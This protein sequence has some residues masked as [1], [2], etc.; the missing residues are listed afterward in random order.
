MSQLTNKRFFLGALSFCLLTVFALFPGD[1][2][3]EEPVEVQ[4]AA[5]LF[6]DMSAVSGAVEA[7]RKQHGVPPKTT[8]ELLASGLIASMPV[9]GEEL[10]GGEYRVQYRFADMDG[11]GEM[12]DAIYS[13]EN[14]PMNVC[15]EFNK[16]YALPPLN[17]GTVFDWQA[18]G[19]KYPGEVFSRDHKVF[20]I[21]WET[22]HTACEINWVI[23]YR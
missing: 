5:K 14:I 4:L 11:Q 22:V 16:R 12:D 3:A 19:G 7:Y 17:D 18:A 21:K 2:L 15:V 23:D 20:A 9:F 13:G 10:G 8:E 6:N 1:S